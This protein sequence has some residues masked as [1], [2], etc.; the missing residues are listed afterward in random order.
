MAGALADCLGVTDICAR[1]GTVCMLL[2]LPGPR[3]IL[4]WFLSMGP[5]DA[6]VAGT[7]GGKAEPC[8]PC[9]P[10]RAA[11]APSATP[12]WLLLDVNCAQAAE[13]GGSRGGLHSASKAL[14]CAR[15][16]I[17][18]WQGRRRRSFQDAMLSPACAGPRWLAL[19]CSCCPS[20]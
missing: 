9:A 20:L 8:S 19:R 5:G 4:R 10:A 6:G 18:F 15:G 13:E 14:L 12:R 1:C 3:S 2:D 16:R 7:C 17:A 11:Q